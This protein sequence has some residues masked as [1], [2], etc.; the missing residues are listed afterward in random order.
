LFEI[1]RTSSRTK[2]KVLRK[3][4]PLGNEQRIF[5]MSDSMPKMT[6]FKS[7]GGQVEVFP[8]KPLATL[9]GENLAARDSL[10][11]QDQSVSEVGIEV[12]EEIDVDEYSVPESVEP[13][14]GGNRRKSLRIGLLLA[15]VLAVVLATVLTRDNRKQ[16]R[17]FEPAVV[18]GAE[19]E[20]LVAPTA[21]PSNPLEL[22]PEYQIL[23]PYVAPPT[24][25][26]DP[27]TPQG[28][29]FEQILS[30]NITEDKEFRV[31]QRF[32][33]MVVYFAMGGENWAWQ[34]GW[35]NF[36]EDECDWHGVAICRFR[37]GRK[38]A[39]GLQIRK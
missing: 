39:A 15:L 9:G 35:S 18:A 5:I 4:S 14:G 24:K 7:K 22:T 20:I 36:S 11:L 30:E 25:L 6:S 37:D 26:L 34:S 17:A 16:K 10:A 32:A 29:A 2:Y 33:M 12:S 31:R 38:I 3:Y 21:A 13:S 28:K 1:D 23:K 27:E 8:E 19:E